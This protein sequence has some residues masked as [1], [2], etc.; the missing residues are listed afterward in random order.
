MAIYHLEHSYLNWRA[1]PCRRKMICVYAVFIIFSTFF[2]YC[3]WL[4][5]F[6]IRLK[7][8]FQVHNMTIN[9]S[10]VLFLCFFFE[11]STLGNVTCCEWPPSLKHIFSFEDRFER[12]GFL[13]QGCLY[14]FCPKKNMAQKYSREMGNFWSTCPKASIKVISK[15]RDLGILRFWSSMGFDRL[16][17]VA[18]LDAYQ[19]TNCQFL[20]KTYHFLLPDFRRIREISF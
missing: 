16:E 8:I 17:A 18:S 6:S 14:H 12:V 5:W 1:I 3:P 20:L 2:F 19:I 11:W 9:F 13:V 15:Y 10:F 7:Q 4:F